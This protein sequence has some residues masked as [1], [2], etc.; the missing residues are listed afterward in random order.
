MAPQ[1]L[2]GQRSRGRSRGRGLWGDPRG[3]HWLFKPREGA[4]W[5]GFLAAGTVPGAQSPARALQVRLTVTAEGRQREGHTFL[6][7]VMCGTVLRAGYNVTTQTLPLRSCGHADRRHQ[8]TVSRVPPRPLCGRLLQE[9]AFSQRAQ[10]MCTG[11]CSRHLP[12]LGPLRPLLRSP[13]RMRTLLAEAWVMPRPGAPKEE[14]GGRL[15]P[16][17]SCP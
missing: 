2:K 15:P 7:P 1:D 6:S 4:G 8:G 9:A 17:P 13:R 3:A 14:C 5:T 16:A 12:I 10:I 11:L